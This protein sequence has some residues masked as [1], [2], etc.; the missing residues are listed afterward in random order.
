MKKGRI[1]LI[2]HDVYQEVN[3]FSLGVA[4]IA[5]VLAR[6]GHHVDTYCQ[7]LF[8]YSNEELADYLDNNEYDIIGVGFLAS[9]FNET[10]IDLCDTINKHKK[11]SWLV[12]GGHGPSPVPEYVLKKTNADIITIGEAEKSIIEIVKNKIDKKHNLDKI[13]GIAWKKGKKF[14][15]NSRVKPIMKLD[16][17]PFPLWENFPID[18][19]KCSVRIFNQQKQEYSLTAT[20]TRGCIN[21]CNFCYRMEEAIRVRSMKNFVSELKKLNDL[22]SINN[23]IFADEMFVLNK[24]RLIQFEKELNKNNLNIRFSCDARVDKFDI[25]LVTILKRCGCVFVNF[26]LESTDNKVLQLMNK[27]TTFEINTKAVES[28]LSVGGIGIGLNFLWGNIGDTESSLLN[29]VKFLK[30]YNT[31]KQIRTIR[32]PTPYPGSG[33]YYTAIRNGLLNGPEDFFN[34]FK[35]SDLY[36]VNFTN[37]PLERFYEL[38]FEA[39]KELILDHYYSTSKDMESANDFIDQFKKLYF[40][41]N[42]KFRGVRKQLY[43]EEF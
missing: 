30:K 43:L 7:D 37:I 22:Y 8:H 1:L 23:F 19:Y 35:N 4:Y 25:E 18:K 42:D 12:L 17:I 2:I 31:Y 24:K 36:M 5:A 21:K 13:N 40:G 33:L 16:K 14:F 34:K 15:I 9:R 26:G 28:V 41:K 3:V 27:N 39:N 32:P 29:N 38:L 11:K 10:I 20:S 6:E